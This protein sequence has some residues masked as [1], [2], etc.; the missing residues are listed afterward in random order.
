ME[1]AIKLRA[2]RP[3]IRRRVGLAPDSPSPGEGKVP[4]RPGQM[5]KG[6]QEYWASGVKSLTKRTTGFPD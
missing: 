5:R 4:E 6:S 2:S 1:A 3:K